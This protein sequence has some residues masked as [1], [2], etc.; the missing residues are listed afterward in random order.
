MTDDERGYCLDFGCP[1]FTEPHEHTY[2]IPALVDAEAARRADA[3]P[4]AHA[5]L[6][7]IKEGSGAL[8]CRC[9]GTGIRQFDSDGYEACPVHLAAPEGER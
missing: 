7:P 6:L 5:P 1:L 3:A 2:G 9:G 8:P 4:D